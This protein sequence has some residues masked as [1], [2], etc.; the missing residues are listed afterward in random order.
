M[1]PIGP[2]DFTYTNGKVSMSV[3]A[4]KAILKQ[5]GSKAKSDSGKRKAVRK[6]LHAQLERFIEENE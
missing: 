3:R 5:S 2:E 1:R 4:F 6:W